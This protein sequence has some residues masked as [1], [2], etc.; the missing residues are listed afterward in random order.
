MTNYE[1]KLDTQNELIKLGKEI[2]KNELIKNNKKEYLNKVMS[3]INLED[4]NLIESYESIMNNLD[5]NTFK[6]TNKKNDL[7]LAVY[8]QNLKIT[9]LEKELKITKDAHKNTEEQYNDI[10]N[11]LEDSDNELENVI[12]S[13]NQRIIIFLLLFIFYNYLLIFS[14][15]E[16]IS[17]FNQIFIFILA[18]LITI[19]NIIYY[20]MFYMNKA[21]IIC[22][23]HC[24]Y[25]N[26]DKI[27]NYFK[28][29]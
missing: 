8:L 19:Y 29:N 11:E 6:N 20:D 7:Y 3:K 16:I 28:F 25:V 27:I 13:N 15:N 22:T 17:H 2:G 5:K 24:A 21:V 9:E 4:I 23:L 18:V 12:K 10:I 1:N 26:K 14:I